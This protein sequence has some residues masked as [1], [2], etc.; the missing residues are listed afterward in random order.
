MLVGVDGLFRPG[1]RHIATVTREASV[2]R[3]ADDE[4]DGPTPGIPAR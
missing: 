1:A 3:D 2:H 4:G